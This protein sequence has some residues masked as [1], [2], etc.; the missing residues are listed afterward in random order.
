MR[1]GVGVGVGVVNL[2]G[3]LAVGRDGSPSRSFSDGGAHFFRDRSLALVNGGLGEP[4]PTKCPLRDSVA[5]YFFA[6]CGIS[7]ILAAPMTTIFSSMA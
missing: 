1:L 3:Q 5:P 2:C 4:R 7:F 6:G